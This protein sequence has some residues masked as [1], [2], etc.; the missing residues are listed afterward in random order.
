MKSG[1]LYRYMMALGRLIAILLVSWAMAVSLLL[2]AQ[3]VFSPFHVVVSNSMSPQIKTGDAVIL[4]DIEAASVQVG[5]VIIFHDPDKKEDLVIHRVIQIE[6]RGGVKF[7]STKGDN[8]EVA[9]NWK[10]SMGEVIGGVAVTVP[11]FGDF[12][13][14]MSTPRG[15][16]GCICIPAVASLLLAM[17]LGLFEKIHA[18]TEERKAAGAP[19]GST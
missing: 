16:V 3:R 10:I 14:F 15:Y 17:V 7:F 19:S 2:I 9:D 18:I 13:D 4:K 8:N 6:D 12:L 5:Q 1:R 11:G